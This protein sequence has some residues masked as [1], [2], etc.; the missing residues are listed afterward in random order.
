MK[1]T[2]I[3]CCFHVHPTD[4][5]KI[6]AEYNKCHVGFICWVRGERRETDCK[7]ALL[8][9]ILRDKKI[10]SIKK[11]KRFWRVPRALVPWQL[12]SAS[13]SLQALAVYACFNRDFRLA[14]QPAVKHFSTN[15]DDWLQRQ[16]LRENQRGTRQTYV[17]V[18][19]EKK[20]IR[21]KKKSIF[22]LG[23]VLVSYRNLV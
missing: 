17:F 11:G 14:S 10:E 8:L 23:F 4:K 16:D 22:L 21:K 2:N 18:Q 7:L 5:N 20:S 13:S 1:A 12:A 6:S 9:Q 3:N 15:C 19:K